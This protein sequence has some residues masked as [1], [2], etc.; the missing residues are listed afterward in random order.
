MKKIYTIAIIGAII[1]LLA[2]FL[3]IGI[4]ASKGKR[5]SLQAPAVTLTPTPKK[6]PKAVL[7]PSFQ[8]YAGTEWKFSIGFPKTYRVVDLTSE[9]SGAVYKP[10]ADLY[11]MPQDTQKQNTETI[12]VTVFAK[13]DATSSLSDWIS[14]NTS[15]LMKKESLLAGYSAI[16]YGVDFLQSDLING[17]EA[18]TFTQQLEDTTEVLTGTIFGP[19]EYIYVLSHVKGYAD[20]V[21]T[22]MLASFSFLP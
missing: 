5:Q 2:L 7:D 3:W 13:D 9:T 22:K 8:E 20:D 12:Y 14:N 16:Y 6:L 4:N 10:L 11:F 21:Y 19:S 18:Y 15:Q 17:Q 1:L